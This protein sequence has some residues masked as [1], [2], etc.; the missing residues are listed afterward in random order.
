M[1][2]ALVPANCSTP[3]WD[4]IQGHCLCNSSTCSFTDASRPI[5]PNGANLTGG[6]SGGTFG[7]SGPSASATSTFVPFNGSGATPSATIPAGI[8][9]AAVVG[10]ISALYGAL[11]VIA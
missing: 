10:L 8:F 11:V 3:F 6:G 7:G 1:P 2:R 5:G 9:G 4:P